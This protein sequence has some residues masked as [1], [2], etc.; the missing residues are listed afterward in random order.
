MSLSSNTATVMSGRTQHKEQHP[1]QK[2]HTQRRDKEHNRSN[3]TISKKSNKDIK[4][5]FKID[6]SKFNK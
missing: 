5:C 3:S 6:L 1:E 4:N 2:E